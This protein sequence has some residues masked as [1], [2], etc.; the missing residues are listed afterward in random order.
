[1]TILP[2]KT[3]RSTLIQTAATMLL[4]GSLVVAATP[5][6]AQISNQTVLPARITAP[7]DSASRVTLAGS[8]PPLA[9]ARNDKGAVSPSLPLQGISIVFSRSAA[10]QSALQALIAAQQTPGSPQFHH[11]LTPDQFAARF[12]V[13]D[14]DIAATESWLEQ[15]GF[16]VT[17]VSRSRNR[18]TF[19]G[20][21]AQ[22]ATAFGAP[23]HY[24]QSPTETEAHFAPSTDLSIPAAL[25][26]AVLTVDNLSSFRPHSHIVRNPLH[27][28]Y[29]VQNDQ[30]YFLTPPDVATIYDINPAYSEGFTG[31]GQTI[32]VV[33]QSAIV[34]SDI[35][36]FQTLLGQPSKAPGVFLVPQTGTS[37]I[38]PGDESESDIDL[39]YSSAIAPGAAINFYYSGN[40]PNYSAFDAIQYVVDNNS[41]NIISSSYGDCEFDIGQSNVLLLDSILS[42]AVTQG[43]TVISAA[44]DTGSSDCAEDTNLAFT[45]QTALAVDYPASSV[46]ALAA[47]GTE[48]P[49]ADVTP[50]NTTYWTTAGTSDIISSAKSYIPEIAWNDDAF[51]EDLILSG[52][53]PSNENPLSSG[54]GGASLYEAL[55]SWQK[56]VPGIP[57]GTNRFVPDIS[58]AASPN[59]PG[60]LYCS[61]DTSG[62][63]S[64][65]T[66]SC[67]TGFSNI[68]GNTLYYN[69]AGGTS[70]V[71]PILSGLVA[72]IN[73]AKGYTAGQGQIAPT[74]YSLAANSTTYASA[75]HDITSGSNAC[76]AGTTYCGTG[77]QTTDFVTTAGYDEATGLGSID[78]YNLLTAWPASGSGSTNNQFSL[79]AT[80]ATATPGTNT[81]ST[82][83]ITPANGFTGTVNFT[84]TGPASLTYACYTLPSATIS[85][86]AAV[87]STL[88]ISTSQ[89]TCPSGTTALFKGSATRTLASSHAPTAPRSRRKPVGAVLTALL[90]CGLGLNRRSRKSLRNLNRLTLSLLLLVT[91]GFA[92]AGLTG[93]SNNSVTNTGGGGTITPPNTTAAGTYTITVVGTSST[94]ASLVSTTTFTL[95]V[96]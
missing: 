67:T 55:P 28:H 82:V 1:M 36:T 15:Q 62:Y 40:S 95:T 16:T 69:A 4:S 24:Y 96:N 41:A 92:S 27:P 11:W 30:G 59:F 52:Q 6:S 2:L 83:T 39:E 42:Q 61:S 87:T 91:L 17:S 73:Q 56:G 34:A 72:I 19:S 71:A 85:G 89:A 88:T 33:G 22:V 7:I 48:F 90:L 60:Y 3:L 35:T 94:N 81:T 43:E 12:G 68:V 9:L 21:A 29:S 51:D 50:P 63:G 14:A 38:V 26:A 18:I 76:Q 77:P 47:G 37:A 80:A 57:S 78:F 8:H 84:A 86:T 53:I 70:F 54:G 25:S 65:Q 74:L 45:D 58:L 46:Y 20:T 5:A 23:L 10:Q 13:A 32:A 64:G 31:T 44:G 93:C 75:F 66:G 79:S 49:S